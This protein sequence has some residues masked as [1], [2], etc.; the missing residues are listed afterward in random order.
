MVKMQH[1]VDLSNA[2]AQVRGSLVRNPGHGV[3]AINR[4]NAT[5]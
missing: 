2:L 5:G 1:R 3:L 4:E